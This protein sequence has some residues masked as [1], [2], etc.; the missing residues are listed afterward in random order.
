MP[1]FY[2]LHGG[3][4]G[5]VN[6]SSPMFRFPNLNNQTHM[7]PQMPMLPRGRDGPV[8]PYE[9]ST[10]P[11]QVQFIS[12]HEKCIVQKFNR[13]TSKPLLITTMLQNQVLGSKRPTYESRFEFGQTS[14]S[15]AQRRVHVFQKLIHLFS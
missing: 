15:S 5:S 12:C 7:R 3:M 10:I 11:P 4:Q 2:R 9:N 6:Q 8:R 1:C 13:C 14:S